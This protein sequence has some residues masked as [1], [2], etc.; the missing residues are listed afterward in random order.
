M[1]LRSLSAHRIGVLMFSL[2][3]F[4]LLTSPSMPAEVKFFEEP[5]VEKSG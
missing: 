1:K 4:G 5:V 2:C 3:V